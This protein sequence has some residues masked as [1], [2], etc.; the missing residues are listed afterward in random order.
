MGMDGMGRM[1]LLAAELAVEKHK[2]T[3][4]APHVI[5]LALLTAALAVVKYTRR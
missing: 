4:I 3:F 5:G 2:A 1:V